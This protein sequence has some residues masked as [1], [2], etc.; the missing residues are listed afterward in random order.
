L[1]IQISTSSIHW[2]SNSTAAVKAHLEHKN[3][4]GIR[5]SLPSCPHSFRVLLGPL[6]HT[7]GTHAEARPGSQVNKFTSALVTACKA[8]HRATGPTLP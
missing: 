6:L 2:L 1:G 3:I 8:H 5:I 7:Q 4:T